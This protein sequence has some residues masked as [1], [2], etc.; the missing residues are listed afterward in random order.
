MKITDENAIKNGEKELLDTIIGDL[1]WY[2]VEKIFN[3]KHRLKLQDD[4]EYRRGDIVIH[5]NDVAY[6]LD[7]DVKVTLSI[8]LDRTGNY[9][10]LKTADA[11]KDGVPDD[12]APIDAPRTAADRRAPAS[13]RSSQSDE[14]NSPNHRS[15]KESGKTAAV[16][17]D[18]S[19]E[20][21]ISYMTSEIADMI[22][23]LNEE[24]D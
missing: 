20:E 18:E 7:F 13:D 23:E 14:S 3:E 24:K 16:G 17:P 4:V 2:I 8:L 6:K 12:K 11:V 1:D 10:E 22:T 21:S 9:V 15:V 19:T 5:D